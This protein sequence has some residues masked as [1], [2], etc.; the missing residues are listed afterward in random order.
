MEKV[1][2]GSGKGLKRFERESGSESRFEGFGVGF[3]SKMIFW[4]LNEAGM[5]VFGNICLKFW[6]NVL[7]HLGIT[8]S[9]HWPTLDWPGGL[10]AA[11]KSAVF[12]ILK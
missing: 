1:W 9:S 7:Q 11:F 6:A 3:G 4:V 2:P 12:S 5:L 10:R 8:Y